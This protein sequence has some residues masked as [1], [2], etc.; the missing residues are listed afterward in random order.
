NGS[1][2]SLF[3]WVDGHVV[4]RGEIGPSHARAA[5]AALARLHLAGADLP[6]RRPGRYEPDEIR[7]RLV[8]IQGLAAGDPVLAQAA[9][10]LGPELDALERERPPALPA[11]LI[12]GA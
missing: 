9:A 11:G 5:G 1:Y 3:P 2:L 10:V 8:I 12:H 6:D 4:P 7:R